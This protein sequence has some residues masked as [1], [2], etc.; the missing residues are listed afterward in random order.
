MRAFLRQRMADALPQPAIAAR[1]QCNRALQVHRFHPFM[2]TRGLIA[3]TPTPLTVCCTMLK[4]IM[5]A[6]GMPIGGAPVLKTRVYREARRRE[7]MRCL[8]V[9]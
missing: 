1:H 6:V 4:S 7:L 5:R 2:R 3:A 9:P 8:L